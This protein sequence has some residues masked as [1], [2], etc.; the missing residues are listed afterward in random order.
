[1]FGA[2]SV[3]VMFADP[4]RWQDYLDAWSALWPDRIVEFPT[5]VET[6]MDRAIERFITSF[7][8]GEITHDGSK[9]LARH[10]KNAVLV[11]GG[12]RKVR[13]GEEEETLVT[14]YLKMAKKGPGALID[15]AVAAVLAHEGRAHAIEHK[16]EDKPT[17]V[18]GFFA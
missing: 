12:K 14:H 2:Y 11:K 8:G 16:L 9:D 10:V 1:V 15:G 6:R 3:A 18:W 13:P 17:E 4:Y 7:A 5:N